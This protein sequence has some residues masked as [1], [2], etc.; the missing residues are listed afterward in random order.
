MVSAITLLNPSTH[1]GSEAWALDRFI[2][3]RMCYIISGY[4]YNAARAMVSLL[5]V[6][7]LLGVL[8]G[9]LAGVGVAEV[10]QGGG[11]DVYHSAAVVQP[12]G[13]HW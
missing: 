1:A 10:Q 13:V 8:L 6:K 7:D 11:F 3:F 2:K 9:L 12:L 4:N 5:L